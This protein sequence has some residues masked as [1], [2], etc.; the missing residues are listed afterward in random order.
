[1]PLYPAVKLMDTVTG[2]DVQPSQDAPPTSYSLTT[3][4]CQ[5]SS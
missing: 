5:Q 4:C 1:M 3:T 2:V